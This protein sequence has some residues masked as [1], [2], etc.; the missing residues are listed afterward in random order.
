MHKY[1]KSS[2]RMIDGGNE[3]LRFVSSYPQIEDCEEI[4]E[5]YA[6]LSKNCEEWCA[7]EGARALPAA[8]FD[9]S[10][11]KASIKA[12]LYSFD[13]K[14]LES[15][16]KSIK[17]CMR[18]AFSDGKGSREAVFEEFHLWNLDTKQIVPTKKRN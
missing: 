7:A 14:I 16:D 15:S 6:S 10:S 2:R 18:I 17:L 3:I 12:P 1:V 13:V 11:Q 8:S 4:S 9:K 5:F